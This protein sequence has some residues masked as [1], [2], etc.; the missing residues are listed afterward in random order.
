M[1]VLAEAAVFILAAMAAD[2]PALS[3]EALAGA[4]AAYAAEQRFERAPET[5]YAPVRY[6]M[7]VAGK[8]VRPMLLLQ[9]HALSG[10][11]PKEALP[12]AYAV[13]LFHNF[14]LVHDDIMDA[15][16]TR[17]GR[18][19]VHVK[20]GEATA[21]LSGDV[22]L[23]DSYGYL[24]NHYDAPLAARLARSFGAMATELCGGQQRDMDMEAGAGGAY[25]YDAYLEMIG[26]KT[27]VLLTTCLELGAIIAE[28]PEATVAALHEAGTAAGRAFQIMDDV[29]DTFS[30][31]AVTGKMDHGDVQRGKQSAPFLRALALASEAQRER[32]VEIYAM[33]PAQRLP[34]VP[35]VLA[36]LRELGVEQALRLEI[37]A[38]TATATEALEK[39]E[40]APAARA[41]LK[42]SVRRLAARE[43]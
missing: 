27:G 43:F 33:T 1:A 20:Y 34:L 2:S 15:A 10:R 9:S 40:G 8:H 4:F 31:G 12:A 11:A 16:D 3:I 18:P 41:M 21:I 19:S 7:G 35:E 30:T 22:M 29:L 24:L 36:A 42:E 13:E 37:D 26:G 14:T 17:R 5:L 32:L 39:V 38:L 6:A 23:I 25:D 28:L